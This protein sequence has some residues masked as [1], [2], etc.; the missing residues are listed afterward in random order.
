MALGWFKKEDGESSAAKAQKSSDGPANVSTK[1]GPISRLLADELVVVVP[2]DLGKEQL[3]EML[4]RRLCEHRSLGD[5]GPF[6]AK[7]L[8]REQG[9]STTL[10]TGLAVPHARMDGLESIVAILGLVPHGLQDPKAPDL[11]IRAMFLFFSPNR[12]EVFTQHL[13]LLRGVSALFQPDFID[14][15]LSAQSGA[16]AVRLIRVKESDV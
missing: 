5:P 12:Q 11:V 8:E 16:E 7:V 2:K 14:V 1:A 4:V 6:L 13:H 10:D 9:I 3:V 15:M